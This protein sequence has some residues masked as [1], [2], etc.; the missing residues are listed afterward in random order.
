MIYRRKLLPLLALGGL[1]WLP[2]QAQMIEE[3]F[4]EE[5]G[6]GSTVGPRPIIRIG[7]DGDDIHMMRFK[8]VM[9]QDDFDTESHV[10]DQTKDQ[11][12]WSFAVL[13]DEAGAL[14]RVPKP[15]NEGV[16]DWKVYAW[17]GVDWV[18]GDNVYRMTVDSIRPEDVETLMADRSEN[19]GVELSWDPVT[20]DLNGRPEYISRYHVYRYSR[21][22]F[23]FSI[24]AFEISVTDET[25]YVDDSQIGRSADMLFY[26]ITAEDQAGNHDFKRW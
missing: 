10:F 5:P 15:L 8:I 22:S 14:L 1:L 13:G 3:V 17:N 11:A 25:Y 4:P 24:R 21:R 12:G 26:K 19:G 16:H 6:D 7:V 20:L 23:F 2:A 9:S 18:E